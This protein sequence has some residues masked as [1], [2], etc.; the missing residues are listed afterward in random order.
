M[1]STMTCAL[2][3][4][5]GTGG[6][7]AN[8]D[9]C[10]S[11]CQAVGNPGVIN[12]ECT[13]GTCIA[14][15]P[16]PCPSPYC[17]NGSVP[18]QCP[19][20]IDYGCTSDSNCLNTLTTHFCDGNHFCHLYRQKGEP[21]NPTSSKHCATPPCQECDPSKNLQC[22]DGFCC[23]SGC[24]GQCQAC[25]LPGKLGT[26][27]TVTSGTPHGSRAACS[28]S[29]ACAGFCDGKSPTACSS[30]TSECAA[31]A[32]DSANDYTLMSALACAAGACPSPSP[33]SC[34]PF[35][36]A[37]AACKTSCLAD[38]DCASTSPTCDVKTGTC[39]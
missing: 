35:A 32:C 24:A 28:G 27:S 20:A 2:P 31:A 18:N 17:G 26:C 3:V 12:S 39:H 22:I 16:S 29:G 34:A 7:G 21:C 14:E 19:I 9:A 1:M 23:D 37:H 36:C 15:A 30:S 38:A 5:N 33:V 4:C 25:D 13:N 10:G 6:C 8:G 11:M